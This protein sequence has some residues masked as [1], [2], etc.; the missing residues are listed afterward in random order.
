MEINGIDDQTMIG[1]SQPI[2]D[3]VVLTFKLLA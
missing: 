1:Q 3:F 2:T